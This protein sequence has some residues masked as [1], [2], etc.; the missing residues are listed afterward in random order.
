MP[1]QTVRLSTL[2]RAAAW[3]LRWLWSKSG[4]D[5]AL[6][7]DGAAEGDAL[8]LVVEVI[9]WL[10][11]SCRRRCP[12]SVRRVGEIT[13]DIHARLRAGATGTP[14]R[15]GADCLSSATLRRSASI[16]DHPLRLRH[17]TNPK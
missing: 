13:V 1:S 11:P 7:V 4:V 10:R 2:W 12:A 15:G 6:A 3:R 9:E 16:I 17:A 14:L 5:T 8:Q